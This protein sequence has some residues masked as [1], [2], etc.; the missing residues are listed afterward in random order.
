MIS[1]SHA[2]SDKEPNFDNPV[3]LG[4]AALGVAI[5]TCILVTILV[6]LRVFTNRKQ[7]KAADCKLFIGMP[8]SFQ[9]LR[10]AHDLVDVTVAA[11]AAH[12]SNANIIIACQSNPLS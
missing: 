9:T 10:E 6:V 8:S 5:T 1:I 4:P 3:S 2:S 11:L 7:L 12:L